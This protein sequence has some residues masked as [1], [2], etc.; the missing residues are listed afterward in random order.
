MII[1]AKTTLL[2]KLNYIIKFH[3]SGYYS[4]EFFT[5][6]EQGLGNK[7]ISIDY[8]V[9]YIKV[10]L[11]FRI[12]LSHLIHKDAI[13][14]FFIQPSLNFDIVVKEDTKRITS[15]FHDPRFGT[16]PGG[17]PA[18][19]LTIEETHSGQFRF[20]RICPSVSIGQEI[21]L[22]NL[23]FFYFAALEM[24]AIHQNKNIQEDF[25][26][27]NFSLINIGLSYRF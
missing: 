6:N 1:S 12:Y 26:N 19:T 24:Q 13:G 5:Y 3:L 11:G 16:P 23:S 17:W 7:N 4:K 10:P 2:R 22:D 18:R 25:K 21:V 27:R 14:G 15:D 9:Q 8:N 20:H